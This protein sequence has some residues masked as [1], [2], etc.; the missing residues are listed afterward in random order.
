LR[1]LGCMALILH[2][3]IVPI[4]ISA[5]QNESIS[6]QNGIVPTR[7]CESQTEAWPQG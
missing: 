7:G 6:K 5:S 4:N 3:V 1:V 2:N